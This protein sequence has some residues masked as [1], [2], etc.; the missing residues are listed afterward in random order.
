VF[1]FRPLNILQAD[2][3]NCLRNSLGIKLKKCIPKLGLKKI[4]RQNAE[5]RAG[6]KSHLGKSA[7][8]RSNIL[9]TPLFATL[10]T[11][12]FNYFETFFPCVQKTQ[13]LHTPTKSLDIN[14]SIL[15]NTKVFHF[16]FRTYIFSLFLRHFLSAFLSSHWLGHNQLP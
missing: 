4:F 9:Q 5:G 6:G 16:M 11:Y 12:N 1:N 2:L 15:Y 7:T 8:L 13:T 10:N 3:K 14:Y